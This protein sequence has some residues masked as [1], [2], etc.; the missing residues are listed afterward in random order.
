MKLSIHPDILDRRSLSL[1]LFKDSLLNYS[2][3]SGVRV[4]Q[5]LSQVAYTLLARTQ[6]AYTPYQ[7]YRVNDSTEDIG[8][9]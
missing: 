7:I 4:A 9:S 2:M 8:N 1:C 3:K 5:R 6:R